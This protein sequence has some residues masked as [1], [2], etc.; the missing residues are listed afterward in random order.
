MTVHTMEVEIGMTERQRIVV[1][2]AGDTVV[3][4]V[5]AGVAAGL[6]TVVKGQRRLFGTRFAARIVRWPLQELPFKC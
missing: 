6:M 1:M 3:V 2:I 4:A 5:A